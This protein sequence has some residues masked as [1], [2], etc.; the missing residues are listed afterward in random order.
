MYII[1]TLTSLYD[2]ISLFCFAFL[3]FFPFAVGKRSEAWKGILFI[4]NE[5]LLYVLTQQPY[6]T[7]LLKQ[8]TSNASI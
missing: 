8:G 2:C 1:Y 7:V 5:A 3:L 4:I 6:I